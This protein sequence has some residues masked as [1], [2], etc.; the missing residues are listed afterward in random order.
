[1]T[2]NLQVILKDNE[3]IPTKKAITVDEPV[4]LGPLRSETQ[5]HSSSLRPPF[6]SN[7]TTCSFRVAHC[8]QLFTSQFYV[9]SPV[10]PQKIFILFSPLT[11]SLT[12]F[13][14]IVSRLQVSWFLQ[15]SKQQFTSFYS[16]YIF[17]F[18]S[19]KQEVLII[20]ILLFDIP[21]DQRKSL[22]CFQQIL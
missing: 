6:S 2:C 19:F 5:S 13:K 21:N 4:S 18:G 1:M 9:D 10:F 22:N 3:L 14:L 8:P 20:I 17:K 11:L 7:L 12:L 16:F 15:I